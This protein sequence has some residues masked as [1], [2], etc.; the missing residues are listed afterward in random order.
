MAV[1]LTDKGWR[2]LGAITR[3]ALYSQGLMGPATVIVPAGVRLLPPTQ[4]WA[5][6]WGVGAQVLLLAHLPTCAGW[7]L[8][9]PGP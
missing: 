2:G 5:L 9:C 7:L 6:G 4:G 1:L 8:E 3:P